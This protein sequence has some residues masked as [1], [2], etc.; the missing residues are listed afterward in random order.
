MNSINKIVLVF[1]NISSIMQLTNSYMNFKAKSWKDGNRYISNYCTS[2]LFDEWYYSGI[3]VLTSIEPLKAVSLP[4][5][6][7]LKNGF[8]LKNNVVYRCE[9]FESEQLSYIR[10]ISF[11]G[12]GYNVLNL[13]ALPRI[14]KN[15]CKLQ[16]LSF[17]M[18]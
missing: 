18:F 5:D 10:L 13:M 9:A 15:F 7:T 8:L 11:R 3:N 6:F 14:G 1:L 12:A 16:H 4:L 17:R 2:H